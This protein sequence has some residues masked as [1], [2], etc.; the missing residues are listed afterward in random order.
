[1][2]NRR[3]LKP[4]FDV[5][6]IYSQTLRSHLVASNLKCNA[7]I[8]GKFAVFRGLPRAARGFLSELA[9]GVEPT[10]RHRRDRLLDDRWLGQKRRR[11]V[12]S[13]HVYQGRFKSF[14][15]ESD[16]YL[17]RAC[18]YVERNAL[19]AGLCERAEQP[20]Q[21]P[22]KPTRPGGVAA[23]REPQSAV[24]ERSLGGPDDKA[25]WTRFGVPSPRLPSQE[26][27]Q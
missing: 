5:I 23:L 10:A 6:L 25:V 1:M 12:G 2:S 19:R 8:P 26:I 4:E 24:W 7:K 22:G 21:P 18:R 14:L 13:G 9:G 17:W 3:F 15:V 20:R 11:S 16:E 27:S